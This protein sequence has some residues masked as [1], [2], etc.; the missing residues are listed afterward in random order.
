MLVKNRNIAI[1]FAF[2]FFY[3]TSGFGFQLLKSRYI[4]CR[5]GFRQVSVEHFYVL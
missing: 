4:F 5:K 1:M 3:Y 2:E